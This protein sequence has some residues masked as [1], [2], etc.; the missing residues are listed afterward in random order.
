MYE[1]NKKSELLDALSR[2]TGCTQ[3]NMYL[4]SAEYYEPGLSVRLE[5]RSLFGLDSQGFLESSQVGK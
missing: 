3:T 4:A 5:E 2:P 1:L